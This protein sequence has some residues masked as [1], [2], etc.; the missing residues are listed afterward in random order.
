MAAKIMLTK[1]CMHGWMDTIDKTIAGQKIAGHAQAGPRSGAVAAA[2]WQG[3]ASCFPCA[4]PS[5]KAEGSADMFTVI[6]PY[7]TLYVNGFSNVFS[8][9]FPTNMGMP[10]SEMGMETGRSTA[11]GGQ[12]LTDLH[13]CVLN[14]IHWP[15]TC[16]RQQTNPS[17]T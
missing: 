10:R 17:K 16:W 15:M 6:T 3:F 7:R 11:P 9:H 8:L 14:S 12:R 4:S 5:H 1:Q 13:R 2:S